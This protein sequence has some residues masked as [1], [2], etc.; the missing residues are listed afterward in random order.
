MS[1]NDSADTVIVHNPKSGSG[2]HTDAIRNRADLL[3]YRIEQTEDPGDAI[4]FARDAATTGVSTIV[5]AGGDGTVHEVVQGIDQ[6]GAFDDVTLGLL[7][8]GT[9]NNFAKN[10]GITD[11]DTGFT[12]LR[13][14]ERRQI[15]LGQAGNHPFV[16]SCIAGL[17]ADSSSETS[18]QMKNRFGVLAYVITTLRSV[19]DFEPLRLTVDI[20][21]GGTETAEWTGEAICVL[22]GNGRRFT[23]DKGNQAHVEDG[24]LDVTVI[25]DVSALDLMSDTLIGQLS[26]EDSSHLVRA[27]TPRLSI[28]IHNPESI[29]F[30]LDGEIIQER[31]LSLGVREKVLRI[32]VG[33]TYDSNL[34]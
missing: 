1:Q 6:A 26:G 33:D 10:I 22:V 34:G 30:S 11:I 31:E 8:V 16:N 32:V 25:K 19:S 28:R 14:G 2:D 4:K 24:L 7:P 23:A 29:R 12:A 20:E 15:D 13:D 27:Q 5:A 9:G 18:G 21:T 3:G 17:T